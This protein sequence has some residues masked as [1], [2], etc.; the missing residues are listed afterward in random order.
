MNPVSLIYY[1]AIMFESELV[2]A[3][4][5]DEWNLLSGVENAAASSGVASAGEKDTMET[6]RDFVEK[7]VVGLIGNVDDTAINRLYDHPACKLKCTITIALVSLLFC[8][9]KLSRN[10]A[11][12]KISRR[13]N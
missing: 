8:T 5:I 10:V 12:A 6:V 3:Q 1:R 13:H 11:N 2:A 7:L 4:L 9:S